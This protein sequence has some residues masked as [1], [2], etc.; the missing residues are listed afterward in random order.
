MTLDADEFMRRFLLHVLPGGFHRIRHYGLLSNG[1]RTVNLARSRELL[2]AVSSAR[3]IQVPGTECA[4]VGHDAAAL[5]P[6][7]ICRHCGAAMIIVQ[8]LARGEP[9]RAPPRQAAAP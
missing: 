3:E 2:S 7:F 5:K 4:D 9:I 6:T 8:T 1:S